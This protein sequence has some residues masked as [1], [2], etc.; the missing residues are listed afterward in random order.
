MR[1]VSDATKAAWAAGTIDKDI[2]I[3]VGTTV[4]TAD[5]IVGNS[6]SLDESIMASDS[7]EFVGCIA[8]SCSFQT[9]ALNG[10]NL[11]GKSCSVQVR[12]G[13]TDWI[14][15][16]TG[17]IEESSKKGFKGLKSITAYDVFYRLSQADA[18][19]WWNNL[20]KTILTNA[21]VS[22]LHTFNVPYNPAAISFRNAYITCFGGSKRKAKRLTALDFLKHVCQ[23][24]GCVG[25]TD[26]YG[27][28]GVKYIDVI[29]QQRLYPA[30]SLFPSDYIFPSDYDSGSVGFSTV[31]PYYQSLEYED[32]YIKQ[33]NK[34]TL[35]DSSEDEGVSYPYVGDNNYIIQGNIF[36]YDQSGMAKMDIAH[37]IYSM[38]DRANFRPFNVKT[39]AMPWLECGDRVTCYDTNDQGVTEEITFII[40]SRKMSGDQMM[41]DTYSA[42]GE[43]DQRIFITDIQ[44]QIDDLQE[45][46]SDMQDTEDGSLFG[47]VTVEYTEP[48]ET[49]TLG[50]YEDSVS[51]IVTEVT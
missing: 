43:Q 31:I 26:G 28:F 10:I 34:V 41:W 27:R 45:Q 5:H 51:G 12:A 36:V 15:I 19:D 49:P 1:N 17:T 4:L 46:I 11:K 8:K 44:S 50:G 23:I 21:F 14:T 24:N 39:F 25:Y 7:L 3:T 37:E 22:F 42:E 16:F 32:Y 6:F 2:K 47:M 48:I 20:G 13:L 30:D 38:T 33:I 35:R 18:C 40:M 29:A 9:D